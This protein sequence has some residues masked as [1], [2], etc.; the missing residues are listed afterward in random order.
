[1]SVE[2]ELLVIYKKLLFTLSCL[3]YYILTDRPP[4]I[5]KQHAARFHHNNQSLPLPLSGWPSS[6]SAEKFEHFCY[7]VLKVSV[8]RRQLVRRVAQVLFLSRILG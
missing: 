5:T 7:S 2:S 4:Q 3:K 1:M 6:P 8:L